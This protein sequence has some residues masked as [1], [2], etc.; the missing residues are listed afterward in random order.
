MGEGSSSERTNGTYQG[1][2]VTDDIPP[3]ERLLLH[4]LKESGQSP[5]LQPRQIVVVFD[6]NSGSGATLGYYGTVVEV[7]RSSVKAHADNPDRWKYVVHIPFLNNTCII[8]A[9]DLI[10][11]DEYDSL[12]AELG[13]ACEVQ[14]DR[15]DH[16]VDDSF[17]GRYR[18]AGQAAWT[19]FQFMRTTCI[20]PEFRLA[21]PAVYGNGGLGGL[22]C[23]VPMEAALDRAFVLRVL[24]DICGKTH[25]R[26]VR[27]QSPPQSQAPI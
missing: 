9:A 20:T 11:T 21:L 12:S 16:A 26:E 2:A 1:W 6:D 10:P 4:S 14:F 25:W 23:C 22:T 18:M 17:S 19:A 7:V 13:P 8:R 3:S 27:P 15:N 5:G 24:G